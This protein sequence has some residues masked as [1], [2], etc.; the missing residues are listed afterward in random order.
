LFAKSAVN[1]GCRAGAG[2]GALAIL[3]L[4]LQ[5]FVASRCS[6][7]LDSFLLLDPAPAWRSWSYKARLDFGVLLALGLGYLLLSMPLTANRIASGLYGRSI[8]AGRL[9]FP[10]ATTI[11]VFA[12]D[13]GRARIQEAARLYDLLRPRWVVVSS[14]RDFRDATADA[15]VPL[16]HILWEH[17][18]NH[19]PQVLLLY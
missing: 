1:A 16:D 7:G 6:F 12:G 9:A 13:H 18:H 14:D 17:N 8:P 10:D 15:G 3:L 5:P 19:S 4:G 2:A 11:V